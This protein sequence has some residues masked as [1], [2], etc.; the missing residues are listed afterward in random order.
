M[1]W[2]S[3]YLYRT[4]LAL[5]FH[6]IKS[7]SIC[8]QYLPSTKDFRSQPGADLLTRFDQQI[9]APRPTC[10]RAVVCVETKNCAILAKLLK[11]C[12]PQSSWGLTSF[13]SSLELDEF[14]AFPALGSSVVRHLQFLP[15]CDSC[16]EHCV[17][18]VVCRQEV[19]LTDSLSLT[20]PRTRGRG[21]SSP[22]RFCFQH[23]G[24]P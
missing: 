15:S 18:G 23:L 22:W 12:L 14:P 13:S 6:F 7:V 2:K 10:D 19:S 4:P 21:G 1:L 5:N 20:K 24:S 11:S 8:K 17:M 16:P 9:V 3:K